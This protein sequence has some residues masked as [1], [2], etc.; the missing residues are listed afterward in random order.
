MQRPNNKGPKRPANTGL[1]DVTEFAFIKHLLE[2]SKGNQADVMRF[3][4]RSSAT[5]SYIARAKSYDE[6]VSTRK[7]TIPVK[8]TVVTATKQTDLFS[9]Q[10]VAEVV[11]STSTAGVA[12]I[13]PAIK[14][15]S[16][17]L[18]GQMTR[19]TTAMHEA[20]MTLIDLRMIAKMLINAKKDNSFVSLYLFIIMTTM[21][22]MSSMYI[23]SVFIK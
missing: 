8:A 13:K 5:L 20:N 22:F 19:L 11:K 21:I 9:G 14:D 3:V 7:G 6:Y 23:A 12:E 16:G 1:V 17:A 15:Y 2:K 18:L 4:G 10:K